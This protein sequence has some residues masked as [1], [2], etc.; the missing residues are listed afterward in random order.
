MKSYRIKLNFYKLTESRLEVKSQNIVASLTDNTSFPTPDPALT[1]V[2]D[3]ITAYSQALDAART[4]DRT[5]IA[6]KN[7]KRQ[8]LEQLLT[9]LAAYVTLTAN[10]D[11]AKLL[12]S[13]FDIAKL[14][15]PQ[16]PI[17]NPQNLQV[18]NGANHGEI[19]LRVNA[20]KGAKA[21]LHQFTPDPITEASVWVSQPSTTSKY[22]FPAL[23]TGKKYWFR[24]AAIG[25]R[26]QVTFSDE[27]W[28]V[29]Q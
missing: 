13:G 3:A 19:L 2:S 8:V 26:D 11:Y 9:T 12:S 1:V 28:R 27:I 14:P 10:G 7:D 29:V 6:I 15:E 21:Y 5:A 23:E 17:G 22:L 25:A 24:V 18:E 16:P 4:G 20:V